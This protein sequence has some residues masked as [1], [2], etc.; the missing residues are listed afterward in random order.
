MI[1]TAFKFILFDKPKSFGA[2]FGIILSVFLI[3]QQVGIFIFLTNAM[4]SLVKNN[5][6]YIWI[7]DTKTT[8]VNALT[9]LDI[10]IGKEIESVPGVKAVYPLVIAGGSAKFE[11]G[12]SSGITLIGSKAPYFNGGPWNLSIGKQED[13]L[14]DGAIFTDY[15]DTKALGEAKVGDYFEVNGKKVYIA[16]Q[17]KGVRGFGGPAYSF[18]TIERARSLTKFSKNKASAFLVEWDNN[19]TQDFAIRNIQRHVRGVK[20]WNSGDFAGATVL[21]V[22][23][24]SGIAF[25]FGTL[26]LFALITGFIIIGLTLYSSAIDR[27]KDYGTLKAIGATNWYIRKLILTQAV[28]LALVGFVLGYT[29]VMGFKNGIAKAGTIF[30]YPD[31]IKLTIFLITLFIAVGGSMFAIRRITKLEPAQVFRG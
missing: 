29:F 17:T 22:L 26:I 4:C 28:I 15:F 16:G 3:G 11:N 6:E 25:S 8:N 12:Q 13:M 5:S 7:T 31:W 30:D 21:T 24:S 1:R 10:R 18:T 19:V 2:L 14:P 20:A 9:P 27:I 23:K